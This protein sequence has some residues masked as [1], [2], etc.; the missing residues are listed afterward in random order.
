MIR[1]LR[2]EAELAAACGDDDLVMWTAQGLRGGARAWALGDAVVASCPA[3]SRHDRLAVWGDTSAAAE[4]VEHALAEVG[5]TYRPWGELELLV[6]V[7]A[8]V[9]VLREGGRFSWMSLPPA[10]ARMSAPAA[11]GRPD[12]EMTPPSAAGRPD[13]GMNPPFAVSR[14]DDGM[15]PPFAVSRPADGVSRPSAARTAEDGAGGAVVW[16]EDEAEVVAEVGA[17]L[18]ADAPHSY[19]V[20]GMAG[21]RRWAGI[22]VD[23]ELAAVAADAWPAPTVGF[24]AGVATRARFRGRGLARLVCGWVTRELVAAHGR[25]TLMVDDDNAA[26]IAVYERLGYGRR[27]VMAARV[28]P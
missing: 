18:A 12:A 7:T 16:L 21:I 15:N 19:A 27:R 17:L 2:S 14:P 10:D 25:A 20:P 9:D 3:I 1:R 6:D 23:G 4:L 26:A 28:T 13:D 8:K 5:P 22:R 24:L 11:P